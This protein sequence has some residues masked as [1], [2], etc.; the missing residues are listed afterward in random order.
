[1]ILKA[2]KNI[3]FENIDHSNNSF[4]KHFH[5]TYVIGITNDGLFKYYNANKTFLSYKNSTRITNPG[6]VHGGKSTSWKYTNFYPSVDLLAQIYEQMFFEKK[7]LTFEK[8]I[9]DDMRLYQLLYS[10]FCSVYSKDTSMQIEIKLIDALSY[11]IQNYTY[12]TK[13]YGNSFN[14]EK[15]INNSIEYIQDM[16][17]SNISL[18]SLA[19][20]VS[21]S[22]Y[23][24]LRIFKKHL[25][26]TP[27]NY[28]IASK[29]QKAKIKIIQGENLIST[30]INFGFSDQSHFI[31][32]FKKLNGYTPKK[33]IDSSNIILY[34]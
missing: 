7:F 21:L 33:L 16:I 18:D 3:L 25:G 1:M 5:D 6:E 28:I 20:N 26:M 31:R 23:H 34:K 15:I 10:L 32:N 19:A 22:K 4:A 11:L 8:H 17:E 14:D 9:I 27:H 30:S 29:V 2:L 24:F 13:S 12:T